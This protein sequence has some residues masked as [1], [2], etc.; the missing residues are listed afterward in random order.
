[1]EK[2]QQHVV[3][4]AAK[5]SGFITVASPQFWK[6]TLNSRQVKLPLKTTLIEEV[7]IIFR[8]QFFFRLGNKYGMPFLQK[9]WPNM[10][11]AAAQRKYCRV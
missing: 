5:A 11:V 10:T 9:K 4:A 6:K 3:P 8:P 1:M 7:K 2:P